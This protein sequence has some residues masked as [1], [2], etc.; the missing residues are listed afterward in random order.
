[1]SE[2][3]ENAEVAEGGSRTFASRW[4]SEEREEFSTPRGEDC[5]LQSP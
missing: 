1:M 2:E 3:D 4:A 5:P